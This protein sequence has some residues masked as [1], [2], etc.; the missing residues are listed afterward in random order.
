MKFPK[1]AEIISFYIYYTNLY[2]IAKPELVIVILFIFTLITPLH[3]KSPSALNKRGVEFG[4][5]KRYSEAISEFN[6]SIEIFNKSSAKVFHN[7]AWVQELQGNYEDAIINYEEAVRRNPDQLPSHERVGFLYYKTGLYGKAVFTGEYVLKIDPDNEEV[8]KWLPDAYRMRIKKQQEDLI[9]KKKEEK[10][11]EEEEKLKKQKEDEAEALKKEKKKKMARRLY[12]T[13]DFMIRTGYYF[14]G[15]EGYKYVTTSGLYG[16]F[17][18][19]IYIN[20]TPRKE[21]EFDLKFGNPYLGALS[22]N[23]VIHTETFQAI[24][25]FERYSIGIGGMGNHYKSSLNFGRELTLHDFK[26]GILFG[27]KKDN[28][29]MRFVLY[30]RAIPKDSKYSSGTTL[31]VDYAEYRF[32]NYVDKFFS[33]YSRISIADYY[34]FDH[35]NEMSN[36]WG[37]YEIS[38]GI[39][40]SKFNLKKKNMTITVDFTERFYMRDLFNDEP[41]NFGNGQGWF[42]INTDTWF[43]GAPFSGYRAPGHVFSIKINEFLTDNFFLYQKLICEMVDRAEDHNEFCLKL[44]VGGTY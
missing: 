1:F 2:N 22:P 7:K 25:H 30:P 37:V 9:A 12:A 27:Y 41:Y 13:F 39:V 36:Y 44:G 23:L 19:M 8:I 35:D 15:D 18:E 43:K 28:Y 33:Y 32:D 21:W 42:G 26:M 4:N 11:K 29:S 17:P 3:S 5:K 34:Y 10:I 6:K 40:L 24:Y 16:N 38:L 14:R 31:D 20:F